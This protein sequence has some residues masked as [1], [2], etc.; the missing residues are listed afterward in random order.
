MEWGPMIDKLVIEMLAN[1]T[2][3]YLYIVQYTCSIK[4]TFP[5]PPS[6]PRATVCKTHLG[7]ACCFENRF[8]ITGR[9][10]IWNFIV[11]QT[12]AYQ[13]NFKKTNTSH[14]CCLLDH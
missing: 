12:I 11:H 8:K 1:H 5:N 13:R 3:P 7:H 4:R 14:K 9:S 10:A 6:D 2:P